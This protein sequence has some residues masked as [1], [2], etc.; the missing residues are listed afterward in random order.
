MAPITPRLVAR[1]LIEYIAQTEAHWLDAA[2]R[3][4]RYVVWNSGNRLQTGWADSFGSR[5]PRSRCA[6]HYSAACRR[7]MLMALVDAAC[8]E[9]RSRIMFDV[10][11]RKLRFEVSVP[12]SH[13]QFTW[14]SYA[15]PP[16]RTTEN[17]TLP[18]SGTPARRIL[19][20]TIVAFS[21]PSRRTASLDEA[22][23]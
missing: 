17:R 22:E 1:Q 3:A 21:S 13:L 9:S 11:L 2:R 19:V 16:G 12:V 5:D 18:A 6:S 15:A 10:S 4:S 14:A 7:S 23:R 8:R 20:S